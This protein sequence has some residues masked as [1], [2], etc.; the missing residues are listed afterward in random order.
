[1]SAPIERLFN[2]PPF[3]VSRGG[4]FVAA[5]R[6]CAVLQSR[7]FPVLARLYAREGFK[8][9]SLRTE[10]DVPRLPFL[11][12]AVFKEFEFAASPAIKL[13]LSLT[14]SGTGGQKSRIRLDEGSLRR[15][16]AS[17]EKVYAALG[18]VDK[19][20]KT[21]Y[22]CMTYDPR[23]AK[24]L[25]TAFTDELLTSFAS[26]GE[27]YYAIRRESPRSEF[28]FDLEGALAAF[29]RF[30]GTGL[31][32]R[33]LGFPAHLQFACEA[34]RRRG[35]PG[36]KLGKKSWVLTGGGWKGHQ[37]DAIPK[38]DFKARI[39]A[40]LGLPAANIRDLYGLVEH[41]IPY[42]ECRLGRMHVPDYARVI[43]RDPRT[44]R[45]LPHGR[46]GLLQ[47]VTPYL[48]SFPSF[49]VLAGDWGKKA[50]RCAC[51]VPGEVLV[52]LGRAG[53]SP[54]RG[55]A[56]TAAELLRASAEGA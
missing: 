42:V 55:C 27:V 19:G 22:V 20:L 40:W 43:V 36:L 2:S 32:L 4:R 45:A 52:L 5:L 21:N 48:T 46:R 31:P 44:L 39:S 13:A 6:E 29:R 7:R 49:S 24:D 38:E 51:G 30:S 34:W 33:V 23:Q 41:G 54:A 15:V 18:M 50:P 16:K 47:L 26:A 14:S 35:W 53:I 17:A 56:V 37:G 8:P 9:G 12:A 3:P 1:M 11:H 28:R 10:R 25:G